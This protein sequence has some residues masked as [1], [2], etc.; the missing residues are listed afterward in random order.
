MGEIVSSVNMPW[1][2]DVA[3]VVEL[4]GWLVRLV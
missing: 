1:I 2:E 4:V 3:E